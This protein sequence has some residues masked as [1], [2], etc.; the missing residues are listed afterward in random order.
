MGIRIDGKLLAESLLTDLE[1]RVTEL[2][3]WGTTPALAVVLVGFNPSSVTYVRQKQKA[4]ERLGAKFLLIEYPDTVTQ[5]QLLARIDKLNNDPMVHGLIV[6]LPLPPSIDEETVTS[7]INPQKDV[8]GFLNDSP[9]TPPIANAAL[10]VL[11]HVYQEQPSYGFTFAQWMTS[12]KNVVM[13]RGKT[14]GLPI[15]KKIKDLKIP[16]TLIHSETD[17][18]EVIINQ[19]DT[20]VSCVGKGRVLTKEM[21]KDNVVLV[22]VG[23]HM[24]DGKLKGDYE[25]EEVK[26]KASY[27][28]PTPGGMGPLNVAH[29]W[30]NVLTAAER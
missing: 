7:S 29:L 14:A 1:A 24:E 15:A 3:E 27:Y 20:I 8:D 10:K 23:L 30:K 25:E 26:E 18:K 16:F 12:R 11:E 22:G 5:E 6:Q 19:A 17:R 21:L 28:T 2:K 9:F 13:G 4:A